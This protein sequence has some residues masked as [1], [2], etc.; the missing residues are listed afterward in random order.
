MQSWIEGGTYE[1]AGLSHSK[2]DKAVGWGEL[3]TAQ[4]EVNG[5]V[6]MLIKTFQIGGS[7]GHRDRIRETMMG[8]AMQVCQ[9]QLLYKDH[10]GW[11][12]TRGGIP[13]TRPV[14][15]G[16]RG[17]NMHLSEIVSDILESIVGK[18]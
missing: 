2:G 12:K 9:I 8:E 14:A 5:H 18:D 17:L 6:S 11:E 10:K 16:H 3:S 15:G 1:K 4:K 13:P 7:W